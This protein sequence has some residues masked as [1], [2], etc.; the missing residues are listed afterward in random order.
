LLLSVNY[1]PLLYILYSTATLQ[2]MNEWWTKLKIG[3]LICG[4]G[5]YFRSPRVD[6][7]NINSKRSSRQKE[8]TNS[9]FNLFSNS[10]SSTVSIS[11][12]VSDF[13]ARNLKQIQFTYDESELIWCIR[14]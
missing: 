14:K 4:N 9:I 3:G 12:A 1:I 13:A 11:D 6:Y 8:N 10:N 7:E 5:F 2:E